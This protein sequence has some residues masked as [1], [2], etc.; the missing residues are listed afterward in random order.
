MK[1]MI[2][3]FTVVALSALAVGEALQ[4]ANSFQTSIVQPTTTE[5]DLLL[6]RSRHLRDYSDVLADGTETFYDEYAQAWRMLGLFV[7]CSDGNERE[8]R[9]VEE[10]DNMEQEEEDE[11][12]EEGEEEEN[13]GCKR[14]ILWAAVRY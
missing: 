9:R 11:D 2:R 1:I 3:L 6:R 4:K 13:K 14:Y 5:N 10:E 8:G 12:E 7:D